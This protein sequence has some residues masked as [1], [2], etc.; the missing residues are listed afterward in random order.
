MTSPKSIASDALL[1]AI[2]AARERL[3]AAAA[4]LHNGKSD[5]LLHDAVVLLYNTGAE[6]L[7]AVDAATPST[8]PRAP[9]PLSPVA[10]ERLRPFMPLGTTAA[11]LIPSTAWESTGGPPDSG[12][13]TRAAPSEGGF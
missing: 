11:D 4:L 6:L 10:W 12:R 1:D 9:A 8:I 5:T 2:W 3:A 13:P 7:K